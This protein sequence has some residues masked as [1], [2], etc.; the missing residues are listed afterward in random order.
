MLLPE[1]DSVIR[2]LMPSVFE[3]AGMAAVAS[4]LRSYGVMDES[5]VARACSVIDE[6]SRLGAGGWAEAVM[7]ASFWGTAAAWAACDEDSDTFEYCVQRVMELW[8]AP[9]GPSVH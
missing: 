4:R 3:A 2:Q 5:D 7:E 9:A 6:A 1:A 8:K